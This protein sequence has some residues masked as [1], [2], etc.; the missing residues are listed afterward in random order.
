MH[1]RRHARTQARTLALQVL[2]R[3]FVDARHG[4]SGFY[5]LRFF[6]E[7]PR[8]DDDWKVTTRTPALTVALAITTRRWQP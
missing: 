8:S 6:H 3:V 7:D 5:L 4:A 1:A 2:D